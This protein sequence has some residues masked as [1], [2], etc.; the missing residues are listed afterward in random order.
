MQV[1]IVMVLTHEAGRTVVGSAKG[2]QG[3]D[4]LWLSEFCEWLSRHEQPEPLVIE[5]TL[6]DC[7]RVLSSLLIL[8]CIACPPL[9][10]VLDKMSGGRQ[11]AKLSEGLLLDLY[12]HSGR[13]FVGSL[14]LPKSQG[15]SIAGSTPGCCPV[16]IAVGCRLV[17]C[18]C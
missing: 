6:E 14:P 3:L 13:C 16:G 1:P 9:S 8:T 17:I 10:A 15:T 7:R 2:L 4:K 12:V 5:D 18:C 11:I